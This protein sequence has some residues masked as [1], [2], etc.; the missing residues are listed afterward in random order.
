[1]VDG[2]IKKEVQHI[3]LLISEPYRV[4]CFCL[5]CLN[6]INGPNGSVQSCKFF[7]VD[8]EKHQKIKVAENLCEGKK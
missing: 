6:V 5:G 3:P 2:L 1:M 4:Y 7:S 8:A